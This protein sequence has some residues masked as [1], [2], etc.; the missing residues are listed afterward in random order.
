MIFIDCLKKSLIVLLCCC[1]I[2][3]LKSQKKIYAVGNAH[4]HNDYKQLHPFSTAYNAGFGS[5]E[6]DIFFRNGRLLVA[7]DTSEILPGNTIQ[8][9]Y[10]DPLLAKIKANNGQV[11]QDASRQLILLIDVKE[12]AGPTLKKL[13]EILNDYTTLVDC[14][15]L[16]LVITG[17]QPAEALLQSYPAWL[18]FDGSLKKTY[19]K[20][21]LKKIALFSDN[22]KNYSKW[23]GIGLLAKTDQLKL[24]SA[25]DKAHA[26]NKPIRFWGAP[27]VSQAWLRF[28]QMDV[29]YINTD[30][31]NSLALFIEKL[32]DAG[33]NRQAGILD[34]V[35]VTTQRTARLNLLV[36]YSTHAVN[37]S[38]FNN[39]QPR[40]TPEALMGV[41]GVFVQKT[42]HGGGSP[43][44]RGLTGNQTLILVDG[45]RLNNAT[46]RYGPNQYLNTIDPYTVSKI[47]VAKGTGSVQYG[48]DAIG[49]VLQVF[50]KDPQ[51]AL[52]T[53]LWS[54]SATAK[55][56]TGDM[57]KTLRAEATYQSVK[58]TII[59]GGTYRNFG[60]VIGGDTTGKQSPSG[61]KEYAFD[62]KAKFLFKP[63][64]E[65]VI[66]MQLV[67]QKQVPV[68]HKVVLENY[69]L[70]EF[71]PQQRMLNYAKLN[72]K[73]K[74][75]WMSKIEL[76]ALWQQTIEGRTSRRNGSNTLR[77]ERDEVN[78]TGFTMDLSS[79]FLNAWTANSGIEIYND[80][81]GSK[82]ND[83]NDQ[84]NIETSFRG[85]YPDGSTYGNY[86]VYSLHHLVFNKWIIEGGLRYNAFDINLTDT[87]VGK[88]NITPASFVYNASLMYKLTPQQSIFVNYNTAFRA[89]NID[90]LGTLGIVDFRYEIPTNNLK[91]EQSV[92]TEVGYK[93]QAAK[94][95]A[96]AS[97]YYMHLSDLI[98]RIRLQGQV[99]N[100]YPVYKKENIEKGYI[101]GMEVSVGWQPSR[102]W[103]TK[104]SISYTYGQSLSK[105]EPLRRIPPFNG[106]LLHTYQSN[107]WFASIDVLFALKQDRLAAGDTDDNRI[108]MGGT[109]GWRVVDIFSGY[110]L[111]KFK[112]NVGLQNIFDV[113]YRTHGSGINGV[114]RSGWVSVMVRM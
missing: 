25:I 12:Q 21:A 32:S 87:S 100:G 84:S 54:G 70:N 110:E 101:K 41:N 31:I 95:S 9:L 5:I 89:P 74:Q 14:P 65:L 91:P 35:I 44:I 24:D 92:N 62:A 88:V 79:R 83:H 39:Y 64:V 46:Y 51:Y 23:N 109:P 71:D 85:L 4:S 40:T 103:N 78:T 50:T 18:Y 34:D 59:A 86:A 33:S 66:A 2:N 114:G 10:L 106:R 52:D 38:Y 1:F 15:S 36:P 96:S 82:R 20:K 57:E 43:F 3:N 28:M 112:F 45:I 105:N 30:S 97:A 107:K 47:E 75:A 56:M 72:I 37:Q 93:L 13:A 77:K 58:T 63:S 49:G 29:D 81:V 113:D 111:K 7:H 17:N 53:S 69:A 48:S 90:D 8:K 108:P 102:H 16:K 99:I 42:N 73:N 26:L 80:K 6:A 22:F 94:W 98:T 55:L 11:Y 61:Y 76:T 67:Q 27:D 104:G 60:D 68:Y 19:S